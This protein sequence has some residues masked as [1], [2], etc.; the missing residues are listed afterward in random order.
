MGRIKIYFKGLENYMFDEDFDS[1]LSY[2]LFEK[3]RRIF[4][5]SRFRNFHYYTFSKFIIENKLIYYDDII[6]RDGVV[7]VIVSSVDDVFLR[8][9]V[10]K[11]LE[12]ESLE[13][14]D[15]T[16][17]L[18]K[19][20][21]LDNP[22]FSEGKASLITLSPIF[23]NNRVITGDLGDVL[24]N[25]LVDKYCRYFNMNTC[26]Y[27]CEF[28]SKNEVYDYYM[29]YGESSFYYN[30]YYNVDI[31]MI[32]HPRLIHF[33]YDVGLGDNNHKGFGMMELY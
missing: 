19:L 33:A 32:A 13:L 3:I 26:D 31:I 11:F 25:I 29:T 21:V 12:G 2:R 22:D 18:V 23:L 16:L 30:Y 28:Y 4:H 6:S 10:C 14:N 17:R 8:T 5:N 15:N 7:S 24:K 1:K 9:L 27:D 20:E